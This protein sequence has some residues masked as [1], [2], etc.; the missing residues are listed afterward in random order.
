MY[1]QDEF[2]NRNTRFSL[3]FRFT[4][5]E[6]EFAIQSL[7]KYYQDPNHVRQLLND[8]FH[9]NLTEDKG[10]LTGVDPI[11]YKPYQTHLYEPFLENPFSN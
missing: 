4:Y 5:A 9:R 1:G 2:Y 7:G 3:R 8:Y 6:P 10:F 11:A